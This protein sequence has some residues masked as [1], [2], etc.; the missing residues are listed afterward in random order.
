LGV[1]FLKNLANGKT[2]MDEGPA[3]WE[4]CIRGTNSIQNMVKK[5]HCALLV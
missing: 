4:Q 2:T 5:K 3:L 1:V